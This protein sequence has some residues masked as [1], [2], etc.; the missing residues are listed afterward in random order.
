MDEGK[1]QLSFEE[2]LKA[3][4]ATGGLMLL[5]GDDG[6]V[7]IKSRLEGAQESLVMAVLAKWIEHLLQKN[8][9]TQVENN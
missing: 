9:K 4:G 2:A 7:R 1:F 5:L 6:S 3:T 8:Q